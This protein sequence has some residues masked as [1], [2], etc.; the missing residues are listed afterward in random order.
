[1]NTNPGAH[2]SV[3]HTGEIVTQGPIKVVSTMASWR[4]DRLLDGLKRNEL[5]ITVQYEYWRQKEGDDVLEIQHEIE[6]LL[7]LRKPGQQ[8]E[9][10]ENLTAGLPNLTDELDSDL[11]ENCCHCSNRLNEDKKENVIIYLCSLGGASRQ[12][13]KLKI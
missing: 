6:P 8:K 13:F 5:H 2:T 1:M 10:S 7:K 9:E 3:T 11:G 12:P 4:N